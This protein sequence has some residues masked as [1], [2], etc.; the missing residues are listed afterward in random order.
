M[1]LTKI[2]TTTGSGC[3]RMPFTTTSGASSV[4]ATLSH[5]H[6]HIPPRLHCERLAPLSRKLNVPARL[7][8]L[9]P[10]PLSG[11]ASL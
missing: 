8:V 5:E 11:Q 3:M 10:K 9:L 6:E 4:T 1:L 7:V 2:V